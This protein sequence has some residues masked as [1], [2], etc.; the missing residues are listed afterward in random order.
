MPNCDS[1]L[2]HFQVSDV[3]FEAA[4]YELLQ[5]ESKILASHLLHHRIPVKHVGSGRSLPHDIAGRSLFLFEKAD[6][7]DNIWN[8]LSP[9]EQVCTS[10]YYLLHLI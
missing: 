1:T 10:Y 8:D 4:V 9:E 7:E 6:G 3:N 5:V 2:I